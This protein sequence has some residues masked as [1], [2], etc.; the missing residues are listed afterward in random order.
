MERGSPASPV[1]KRNDVLTDPD[2]PDTARASARSSLGGVSPHEISIG[3]WTRYCLWIA[4]GDAPRAMRYREPPVAFS[5]RLAPPRRDPANC[6]LSSASPV[7][8]VNRNAEDASSRQVNSPSRGTV[9]FHQRVPM[10]V[11]GGSRG[12]TVSP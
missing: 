9:Q 8:M 12:S 10:P 5:A 7:Q 4:S 1:A 3:E 6:R 11:S 2:A